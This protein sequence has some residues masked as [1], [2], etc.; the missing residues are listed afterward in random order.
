MA[1]TPPRVAVVGGGIAGSLCALVL[2]N[3]GIIPTVIDAGKSGLGGRL[4][5]GDRTIETF[6]SSH[7]RPARG[8]A[9]VPFVRASDPRLAG[10]FSML[11]AKGLLAKWNA[12][13]GILGSAGGGFL[14][15]G[16]IAGTS[17]RSMNK[18]S[19][20][21]SS[22]NNANKTTDAGDFCGFID[23][24]KAPT[25]VGIPTMADLCPGI[26]RAADIEVILG[27]SVKKVH[28]APGGGWTLSL[29]GKDG[30]MADS[31]DGLVLAT[32]NPLLASDTIQ[33]IAEGELQASKDDHDS[34][35]L[36]A[37]RLLQLSKDLQLIREARQPIVSWSALYPSDVSKDRIPF[38]AVAIPGS[39]VMQ[40]LSRNASKPNRPGQLDGCELWTAIS[41]SQFAAHY[42]DAD[43][44]QVAEI[45]SSEV[46]Q[47]WA[48]YF[49]NSHVPD[50]IY[51]VAKR[52]NAAFTPQ[53]L[54]LKEDSIALAPWR[55]ALCGDYISNSYSTPFEAAALS[56]LDAGER[57]A[58]SFFQ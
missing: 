24:S 43:L 15:S 7:R 32:H 47:L 25:Y 20:E 28:L 13:F 36:I 27:S 38:D 30:M 33:T 6:Q 21:D 3:R 4:G 26:C 29:D 40:F 46:K 31:Y 48:P 34:S 10:I 49:D 14:P 37:D 58:A 1:S 16:I 9:G 53:T 17:V 56:G 51:A 39:H 8:D 42:A 54:N 35:S 50:P 22:P 5:G 18:D 23:G 44:D 45:M 2:K 19:G 55:L 12:R 41:T 11:E 57:A 52:W